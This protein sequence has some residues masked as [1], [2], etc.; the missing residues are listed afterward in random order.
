[1]AHIDEI[2]DYWNKRANGFSL[3][4]AEE[5]ETDAGKRWEQ[6]FREQIPGECAEVLDD[7]TGAGFF[8]VILSKL[9]HRVTAIDYSDQM[10]AQAQE[11]FAALGIDVNV[12]QMDAQNLTFADESFDAVVSR[13]VLW[14]L[15]DPAK[16]YQEMYRVLRPGGKLLID[17]GNMYLYHHD[18][19]YAAQHEKFVEEQRKRRETEGGLH[20]KHNVD[21]VDFS[22]IEE[23]AKDLPMSYA[24]RPQWDFQELVSLG[25]RDIHVTIR[26]GELP[27][28]FLIAAEKRR[29]PNG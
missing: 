21:H 27:M 29:I 15:D 23:I 4:V 18:K 14:N 2:K 10:V 8:P 20:G 17:D 22:V 26:G 28:G 1:M 5:L 19:E 7:G 24:R 13:N 12:L 9:G 6:I 3:A 11:R 16:A 25:F